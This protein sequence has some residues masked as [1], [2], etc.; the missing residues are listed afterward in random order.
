VTA[1]VL[2]GA[3]GHAREVREMIETAR[4]GDGPSVVL[5]FIDEDVRRHGLEVAGLPVLGGFE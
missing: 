4:T 5:G 3:G 1:V 2:I